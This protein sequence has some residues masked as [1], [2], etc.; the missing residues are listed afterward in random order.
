MRAL[1][2][3]L[4]VS[5]A[6]LRCGAAPFTVDIEVVDELGA[7]IPGA[8]VWV[9]AVPSLSVDPWNRPSRRQRVEVAADADGRCRL[10][11][12]HA[13]RALCPMAVAPGYYPAGIRVEPPAPLQRI[14]LPRRLGA[15]ASSRIDLVTA[16]LPEDGGEHGFDLVMG[17]F[18]APLGVGK[19]ADVWIRGRCPSA[20][21]SPGSSTA[22]VDEA[23]MR[24]ADAGDGVI[25]TPRPGESGFDRSIS[26]ACAGMMLGGIL[27]P[28]EAPSVGYQPSLAYR[29]ARGPSASDIP[30]P[31]RIG[32]PQWIFRIHREGRPVHGLIEDLGWL[33]DGR[34][35][36]LYR[37]S[38]EPGNRSLE[39]GP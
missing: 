38:T 37:I 1:A 26:P 8:A 30:G 12:E 29:S 34:L 21:L 35:R 9:D 28:R 36:L 17:A 13:L 24:F 4:L 3:R 27:A 33:P 32:Q 14:T 2:L 15:S 11:G 20:R 19:R 23:V 39:F 22:Y 6:A 18:V 31:G 7:P 10:S 25:G 16:S 5:L